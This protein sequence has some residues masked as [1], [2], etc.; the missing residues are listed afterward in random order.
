MIFIFSG[1]VPAEAVLRGALSKI[2]FLLL[3]CASPSYAV[4]TIE[5]IGGGATQIPVAIVPLAGEQGLPQSITAVVGADLARSGLFK[6]VD[7]GGINP[8]P[9]EPSEIRYGDWK[10]RGADAMVIGSVRLLPE[11]KLEVRFRLMDVAKQTQLAGFS[12]TIAPAQLRLTA[13]RIADVVYEKLT[14]DPGVFSTKISYVVKQGNHYELQIADADGYDSQTVVSSNDSIISPTWSP[15]GNRIAYVS[16]EKKRAV[17]Y[18]Q[19]LT[20]GKRS[21]LAG[22]EGSNSAPAWAPDG[23]RLAVVLSKDGISQVYLVNPDGS[24]LQRLTYSGAIDTEPNFSKDGKWILFTSDRG[25]SPQIYRM[26]ASGG[27]AERLTFEGTY[28]VSP[29]FSPDGKS[30]AFIQ[31]GNGRFNVAVQDLATRQM[32]VLTDSMLDESPSYAPS[33]KIILYATE[34]G[35]RGVLAAVSNDG[36]IKQRLTVQSG[37]VREPS[38]G[39][40]LRSQ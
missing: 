11:A 17:T 29:R 22:Y 20:T 31:R 27:E 7:T 23:N 25:G 4:L 2:I 37:D 14:G 3:L 35:G 15:E 33:G 26:P 38:W 16:F 34:I 30:F 10:A 18:V 8:L 36:K 21:L 1:R 19:S 32:Q 24:G 9:M 28:N 13:H 12:Y 6:L 39:P 5:I 40:F